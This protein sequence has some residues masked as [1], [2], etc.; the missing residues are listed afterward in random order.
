MAETPTKIQPPTRDPL[1][2]IYPLGL[3]EAACRAIEA[4][5][6]YGSMTTEIVEIRQCAARIIRDGLR[7][8]EAAAAEGRSRG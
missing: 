4:L 7:S 5:R 8:H 2:A 6:D 1:P 3:I